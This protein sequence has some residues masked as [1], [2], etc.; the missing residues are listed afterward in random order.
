MASEEQQFT[1]A[2]SRLFAGDNSPM[3]N[4][5]F[6]LG[7]DLLTEFEQAKTL[8]LT[9]EQRWVRDLRQYKGIYEPEV[10]A[11]MR[12]SKSFLRK[13]RVKV[14]SVDARLMDLLFPANKERNYSV[15]AT[16]EPSVPSE[17]ETEISAMLTKAFGKPPTSKEMKLAIRKFVTQAAEKMGDRIDDQLAEAKYRDVSRGVIHSGNLY[18]TGILKGPLVERR[19]RLSYVYDA[20]ERRFV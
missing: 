8:R 2:A 13:T 4:P 5:L 10:E 3:E 9:A 6:N 7:T 1:Q 14:E 12:G 16:P 18:G 20:E 17:V 15:D 19:T 11:K